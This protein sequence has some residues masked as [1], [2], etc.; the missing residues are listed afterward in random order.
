MRLIGLLALGIM[1]A[2]CGSESGSSAPISV[3]GT[4]QTAVSLVRSDCV[5]Q[6]EEQHPTIV[7]QVPGA[8][9]VTLTHA[10][11]SYSGTLSADGSFATTVATQVVGGITYQITISGRFTLTALDAA[12]M[13]PRGPNRIAASRPAGLVRKTGSPTPCHRSRR[14]RRPP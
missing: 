2:G 1:V 14:A 7:A 9:A 10:G 4:Y 6:M 13:S 3:G 11:N 12:V 5:D 8:T